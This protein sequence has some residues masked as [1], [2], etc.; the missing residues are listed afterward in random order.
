MSLRKKVEVLLVIDYNKREL[1]GMLLVQ[2]FLWKRGI[3][4]KIVNDLV[5]AIALEKYRPKIMVVGSPQLALANVF[6]EQLHPKTRRPRGSQKAAWYSQEQSPR[7][8]EDK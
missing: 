6:F 5:I 2:H 1:L 3:R 4:A 8:K 7:P